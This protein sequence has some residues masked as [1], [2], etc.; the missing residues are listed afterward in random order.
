MLQN[1]YKWGL[2][3]YLVNSFC[4]IFYVIRAGWFDV[5]WGCLPNGRR[6]WAEENRKA[7]VKKHSDAQLNKG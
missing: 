4:Q 1:C 6:G 7:I 2:N 5:D 3:V